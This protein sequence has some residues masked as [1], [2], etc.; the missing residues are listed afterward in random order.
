MTEY[1]DPVGES[2]RR[3]RAAW[4]LGALVI[5]AALLVILM[6]FFFISLLEAYASLLVSPAQSVIVSFAVLILTLLF[7]PSGLFAATPR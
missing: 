2:Q 5:V 6:L 3:R 1:E 4:L 7:R